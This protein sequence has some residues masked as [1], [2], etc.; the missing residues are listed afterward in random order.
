MKSACQALGDAISSLGINSSDYRL[1]EVAINDGEVNVIASVSD[2]TWTFYFA[3]L[4]Q[5][6]FVE[7]SLGHFSASAVVNS[8]SGHAGHL[9]AEP[10]SLSPGM[11]NFTLGLNSTQ[12]VQ[13][14]RN[15]TV[16]NEGPALVAKGT[17]QSVDLRLASVYTVEGGAYPSVQPVNSS[18]TDGQLRLLWII[19]TTAPNNVGYFAVD[20]ETGQMVEAEGES[21]LPCGGAPNCGI[22]YATS[23]GVV[24]APLFGDTKEARH[25]L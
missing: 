19:T 22:A 16:M 14:V 10:L 3:R 17:V 12:A 20:T 18:T 1:A 7:G 5:G 8:V 2:P 23:S 21:T 24:S 6:Y 25:I 4:Y 9:S 11:G 13:V 15:T